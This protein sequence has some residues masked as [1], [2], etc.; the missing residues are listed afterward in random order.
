MFFNYTYFTLPCRGLGLVGLA[1]YLVYWPTIV[2]QCFVT[3]GWVIWP[4]K[5]VPAMAYNVF[6]G[7]LNPTLLLL[8]LLSSSKLN[9]CRLSLRVCIL[10]R[11]INLLTYWKVKRCVFVC[12][13]I[14]LE[15]WKRPPGCLW[16]TW[17][18][19]D[20]NE[21]ESHNLALTEAVSVAQNHQSPSLR[22]CWLLVMLC[23]GQKWW[24]WWW[25]LCV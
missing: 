5:I 18:K 16:I 24:W 25:C 11:L 9:N 8:L 3:V 1:L 7:T 10:D 17:M 23:C 20:L 14:P 6:G 2:L 22:S 12:D 4:I 19:T 13:C 15:D 21:F